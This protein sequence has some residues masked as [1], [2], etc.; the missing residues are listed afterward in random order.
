MLEFLV[1]SL[2]SRGFI[3]PLY[4]RKVKKEDFKVLSGTVIELLRNRRKILTSG[5]LVPTHKPGK[6]PGLASSYRPIIL[7][8]VVRKLISTMARKRIKLQL[9]RSL[10]D[11]QF[12]YREGYSKGDVVLAHKLLI[13]S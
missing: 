8:S 1:G 4:H 10:M 13:A 6:D 12:A 9:N 11:N 3:K 5:V 2:E 7:L